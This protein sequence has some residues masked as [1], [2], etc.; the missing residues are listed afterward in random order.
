MTVVTRKDNV[1]TPAIV[2]HQGAAV[3]VSLCGKRGA[4]FFLIRLCCAILPCCPEGSF[5]PGPC[6]FTFIELTTAQYESFC[7]YIL[8]TSLYK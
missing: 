4:F 3:R 2:M 7:A 5:A 8:A 1:D 6:K